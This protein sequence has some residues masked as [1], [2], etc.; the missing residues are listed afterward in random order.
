L[1]SKESAINEVQLINLAEIQAKE[2]R[3]FQKSLKEI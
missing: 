2:L 3:L 1:E